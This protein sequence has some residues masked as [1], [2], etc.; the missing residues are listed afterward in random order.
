[1][2]RGKH[3]IKSWCNTQKS[4]SLSSAE[5]ELIAAVKTSS[6]MIGIQQLAADW[7]EEVSARLFVDSSAAIGVMQ[8]QGCGKMRHVRVGNLWV[9]QKVEDGELIV[10]KV[11]GEENPADLLTKH[12]TKQKKDKFT[13]MLSQETRLGKAAKALDLNG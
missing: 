11:R 12:V 5:A 2:R 9:Q 3:F 10:A 7:G 13:A 4:I 8:R 6:E 1:M